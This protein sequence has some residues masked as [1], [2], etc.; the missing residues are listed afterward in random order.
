M[1]KNVITQKSELLRARQE[2]LHQQNQ[3]CEI[4]SWGKFTGFEVFTWLNPSLEKLI[5][6]M[7]SMPFPVYW[8]TTEEAFHSLCLGKVHHFPNVG[9]LFLVSSKETVPALFGDAQTIS[10]CFEVFLLP[11][12]V[13][14]QG[15]VLFTAKGT[16][17]AALIHEFTSSFHY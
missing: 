16:E 11:K 3:G 13:K 7:E 8:V 14:S 17:G 15:I 1:K 10:S 2:A 6:T 4:Q 5:P 12:M 9:K